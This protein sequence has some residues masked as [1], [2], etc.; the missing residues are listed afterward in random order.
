MSSDKFPVLERDHRHFLRLKRDLWDE[1][2][3]RVSLMVGAGVSRNAQP[4][5]GVGT[6]FPTW[7]DLAKR[8]WE[9]MY[10]TEGTSDKAGN[11]VARKP[12][13]PERIASE[14]EAM[15]GRG[16][17]EKLIH[18]QIPDKDYEPG[19]FH[20]ELLRLPWRDV[21]TTNYDTLLERTRVPGREYYP[22]ISAK[23]LATVSE[24][25]IF[26]LHGSFGSGS[27][28]VVTDEDYRTYPRRF[29]S[30]LHTVR[31]SLMEGALVLVGS[32]GE[33]RNFVDW[34]GWIRDELGSHRC[35]IYLV[36]REHLDDIQR[37][38]LDKCG[39]TPIVLAPATYAGDSGLTPTG[40][41]LLEFVRGLSQENRRVEEW[42]TELSAKTVDG[43]RSS[44]STA[45]RGAEIERTLD[46]WQEEREAYPGWLI[47]PVAE[48]QRLWH[49]TRHWVAP[50]LAATESWSVTDRVVALSELNWRLE[51][52]LVPL[53]PE[54]REKIEAAARSI[55]EHVRSK[56]D[57]PQATDRKTTG[58]NSTLSAGEAWVRLVLALVREARETSDETRWKAHMESLDGV[59][60]QYSNLVDRYHYEGV[61]WRL[62]QIDRTAAQELLAKWMPVPGARRAPL[63]RAGLLAEVGQLQMAKETLRT[64]LQ[65]TRRANEGG[66]G[67]NVELLSVEGWC[68]YL[69]F[70]VEWSL[71]FAGYEALRKEFVGRWKELRVRE[72][73]PWAV[74]D[75]YSGVLAR[76]RPSQPRNVRSWS[77]FD[78]GQRH[79]VRS[80][81]GGGIDPWLPAFG[82]LRWL[83]EV[84]IPAR[85]GGL[86]AVPRGLVSACRWVAPF[87]L[88]RSVSA[89]VR[90]GAGKELRESEFIDRPHVGEMEL[91]AVAKLN[92]MMSE[93]VERE[94]AMLARQD[95]PWTDASILEAAVE[96]RSRLTVRL[97]QSDLEL[98]FRGALA[99]F[100]EWR[101]VPLHGLERVVAS[102]F[103][104]LY[105]AADDAVLARWFPALLDAPLPEDREEGWP[106]RLRDPLGGFPLDRLRGEETMTEETLIAIQ[107]AVTRLLGRGQLETSEKRKQVLWRLAGVRRFGLLTETQE[108]QFA[109]LL[110]E[111]AADGVLPY[112][113]GLWVWDYASHPSAGRDDLLRRIKDDI[114]GRLPVGRPTGEGTMTSTVM[115]RRDAWLGEAGAATK[116]IVEIPHERRGVLEWNAEERGLLWR[117]LRAWWGKRRTEMLLEDNAPLLGTGDRIRDLAADL[118]ICLIRLKVA[119]TDPSD[120]SA[121][122]EVTTFLEET[123]EE[124][125]ELGGALPYLLIGCPREKGR[126]VARLAEDLR[127][128]DARRAMAAA[129]GVRHWIYLAEAEKVGRVPGAVV[130]ALV[131][132][133]AFR[134]LEGA[135]GCV[136]SLAAVLVEKGSVLSTVAVQRLVGSLN[137][138]KKV[139]APVVDDLGPEGIPRDER[140]DLRASVGVLVNALSVW[141]AENRVGRAVPKLIT[142]LLVDY[143]ADPLPEVRRAVSNGRWRYWG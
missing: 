116:G 3:S 52:A 44:V 80:L 22:V 110:W 56:R 55:A 83:E 84:G 122:R 107:G 72:C 87:F 134:L 5:P 34:V 62:E 19:Q 126:V 40:L 30:M 9:Q 130:D 15:F 100:V 99:L 79:V 108:T 20:E 8:M 31:Q 129:R 125:V 118:E 48:R 78:P 113:E 69:L 32:S 86:S 28:L 94:T 98:S 46:R 85:T 29:S 11:R 73:D 63:W 24:P 59:V 114:L 71:D 7:L 92:A 17:L 139:V 61:L 27:P 53:F 124:R 97:A 96:V 13:A 106:G 123:R 6:F 101:S 50:I 136:R 16:A 115:G 119:A 12:P 89:L 68:T 141:W 109:A 51:V 93:T 131:D 42:A 111:D 95:R 58:R 70:T 41:A 103:E 91:E 66:G 132:R 67:Q 47:A 4:R 112:R 57:W 138:W 117:G 25:R 82:Y 36:M 33:D 133:V 45:D 2:G 74:H 64:A 60:Q 77:A 26:K 142:E 14:F 23:D 75:Y 135:Q 121:W 21:F 105:V 38:H 65:E 88:R 127:C 1:R 54:W 43:P 102:W 10:P 49:S 104:R 90:A 35:A 76:E 18:R 39:V 137:A 143:Q 128:G 120:A 81:G 140:P 37:R